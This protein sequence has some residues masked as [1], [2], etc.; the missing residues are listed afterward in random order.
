MEKVQSNINSKKE[1][2]KVQTDADVKRKAVKLVISHLKKKIAKEYAGSE[3]VQEWVGEME[4]LLEKNEFELSEYVQMR[5]E[6]NDIIERTMD[7][8]MRF[9][10]R[11]SWY[12]FG[13]AL[14]KKVKKY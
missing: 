3:L 10:L 12:S 5:R 11:D 1:G 6:L 14:D 7:E 4:K 2:R 9:K 13:R 8:E